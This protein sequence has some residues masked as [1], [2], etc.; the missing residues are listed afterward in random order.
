MILFPLKE[1]L[2]LRDRILDFGD[3]MMHP[4]DV[5]GNH[6]RVEDG[7]TDVFATVDV[8]FLYGGIFMIHY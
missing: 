7:L 2:E 8:T 6:K 1:N 4:T 5:I 3:V